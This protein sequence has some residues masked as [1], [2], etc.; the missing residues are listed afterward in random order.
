MFFVR[1]VARAELPESMIVAIG[2]I[3]IMHVVMALLALVAAPWELWL[4]EWGR[5]IRMLAGYIVDILW[6]GAHASPLAELLEQLI[7]SLAQAALQPAQPRRLLLFAV[8]LVRASVGGHVAQLF[9][10]QLGRRRRCVDVCG[11]R[12][13]A[14]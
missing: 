12:H 2:I 4:L 10:L 3:F 1:G 7:L 8:A 9:A 13:G 5:V 14:R 6:F 11:G